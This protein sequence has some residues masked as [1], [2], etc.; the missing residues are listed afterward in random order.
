MWG[1]PVVPAIFVLSSFGIAANQMLSDPL[2]S[3][4]GLALVFA[5]LP[6]YYLWARR[7]GSCR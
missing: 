1:Y 4:T 6:V 3:L 5:G 2:E 7:E